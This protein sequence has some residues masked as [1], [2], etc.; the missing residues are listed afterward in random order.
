MAMAALPSS[1]HWIKP[2]SLLEALRAI[3][4]AS[5]ILSIIQIP[6]YFG[7][8]ACFL[9]PWNWPSWGTD[10]VVWQLVCEAHPAARSLI[11]AVARGSRWRFRPGG[12]IEDLLDVDVDLPKKGRR[13]RVAVAF[14]SQD[15]RAQLHA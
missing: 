10:S 7:V 14:I 12:V 3:Q 8:R 6:R 5:V 13:D 15:G 2:P 1:V 9:R 11:R 4:P